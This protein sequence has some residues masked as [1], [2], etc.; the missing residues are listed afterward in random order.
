MS[1]SVRNL[2]SKITSLSEDIP[3]DLKSMARGMDPSATADMI[4]MYMDIPVTHKQRMLEIT[5]VKERLTTLKSVMARELSVLELSTKIQNE[6]KDEMNKAQKEFYL[7]KEMDAIKKELG[8]D[9]DQASE[10][11]DS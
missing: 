1:V 7:R 6:A 10:I 5:N 3:S 4:A 2:L 9:E 11:K 8:E